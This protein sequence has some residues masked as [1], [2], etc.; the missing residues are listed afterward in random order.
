MFN[1]R[2]YGAT[3]VVLGRLLGIG[4]PKDVASFKEGA[5]GMVFDNRSQAIF[6]SLPYQEAINRTLLL[7]T[8]SN[9]LRYATCFGV[10]LGQLLKTTLQTL[11]NGQPRSDDGQ[12]ECAC[13]GCGHRLSDENLVT[14]I[15]DAFYDSVQPVRRKWVIH[16]S[17]LQE[18]DL[19]T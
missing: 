15:W 18:V 2:R 16:C 11:R 13:S 9:L 8:L 10:R 7:L 19:G 1:C 4:V 5:E 14:L 3:H 17:S 12:A 6:V